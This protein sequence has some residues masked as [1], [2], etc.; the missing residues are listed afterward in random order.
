[1]QGFED[2]YQEY[3]DEDVVVIDVLVE[4]LYGGWPTVED[5]ATWKAELG[6]TFPVLA[7]V[8]GSFFSTYGSGRDVFVFYVIDRDGVISWKSTREGADTLELIQ[9]EI[10][11]LVGD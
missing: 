8:E 11:R 5:A 7:D 6:L 2:I 9:G 1:M 3:A 4:D 10:E